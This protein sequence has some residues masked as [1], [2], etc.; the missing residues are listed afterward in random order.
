MLEC[1]RL[2]YTSIFSWDSKINISI[3][4]LSVSKGS[5]LSPLTDE[6]RVI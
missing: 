6:I 2:E 4:L 1:F 3:Y 5:R